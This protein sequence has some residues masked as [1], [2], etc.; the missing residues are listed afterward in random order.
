[1][2]TGV[3]EKRGSVSAGISALGRG[4]GFVRAE[5]GRRA[6]RWVEVGAVARLSG[7]AEWSPRLL[8]APHLGGSPSATTT[9]TALVRRAGLTLVELLVVIA[10]I[11]VLVALLLPAVQGVRESARRVSCGN[12]LRQLAL[13]CQNYHETEGRLPPTMGI[14]PVFY[15]NLI[16]VPEFRAR[17]PVSMHGRNWIVWLLPRVEEQ[18]LFDSIDFAQDGLVGATNL[19]VAQRNLPLVLC[20]SDPEALAP[21]PRSTGPLVTGTPANPNDWPTLALASYA[22]SHGD[23]RHRFV[24]RPAPIPAPPTDPPFPPH[25]NGVITLAALRGVASRS[26]FS[27]SFAS[28]RDGLSNTIMLGEIVPAWSEFQSWANQSFAGMLNP[29]NYRNADYANGSITPKVQGPPDP[30]PFCSAGCNNDNGL[31]FRSRHQGG[32]FFAL[33][34]GSVHFLADDISITTYQALS[35]RSTGDVGQVGN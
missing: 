33:C 4:G 3:S 25:A 22:I 35:T 14:S 20:P 29:I 28:V 5:S 32:A 10:I 7:Q 12:S 17:W 15:P 23:H 2:L 30:T 16:G 24:P 18:N 19:A 21:R 1:M 31:S 13:G 27:V 26:G 11:A 8:P 6:N 34:D 9:G